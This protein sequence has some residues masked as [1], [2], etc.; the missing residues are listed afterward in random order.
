MRTHEHGLTFVSIVRTDACMAML[1]LLSGGAQL[2]CSGAE[3]TIAN[4]LFPAKSEGFVAIMRSD[5][6]TGPNGEHHQILLCR[7]SS[8]GFQCLRKWLTTNEFHS[9]GLIHQA[10]NPTFFDEVVSVWK[11]HFVRVIFSTDDFLEYR[12]P[13]GLQGELSAPGRGNMLVRNCKNERR[14][15]LMLRS[16]GLAGLTNISTDLGG[17]RY[18]VATYASSNAVM[19]T[20]SDMSNGILSFEI[21]APNGA[22]EKSEYTLMPSSLDPEKPFASLRSGQAARATAEVWR[23]THLAAEFYPVDSSF[24]RPEDLHTQIC[25]VATRNHG[26]RNWNIITN[27]RIY[28]VSKSG[29]LKPILKPQPQLVSPQHATLARVLLLVTSLGG[30]AILIFIHLSLQ[31]IIKRTTNNRESQ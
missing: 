15:Y 27:G 31:R 6:N 18:L 7:E 12:S 9:V 26:F 20:H 29:Q 25:E 2:E 24:P 1:I 14:L 3:I 23:N 16:T 21:H 10:R 11:D 8:M 13:L 5:R 28:A 17:G 30:L 4:P 19:E 22:I